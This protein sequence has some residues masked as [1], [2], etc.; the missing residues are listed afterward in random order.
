MPSTMC[1]TP[2]TNGQRVNTRD[3]QHANT[4]TNNQHRQRIKNPSIHSTHPLHLLA[5]QLTS[6]IYIQECTA[7]YK[8]RPTDRRMIRYYTSSKSMVSLSRGTGHFLPSRRAVTCPKTQAPPRPRPAPIHRSSTNTQ[9]NQRE[10]ESQDANVC[11]HTK[12]KTYT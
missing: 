9:Q 4:A 10:R 1:N 2:N 5:T 11:K 8:C 6:Q 12:E 7:K 3:V